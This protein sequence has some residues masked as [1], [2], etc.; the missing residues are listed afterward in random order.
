MAQLAARV[1][2]LCEARGLLVREVALRGDEAA[3]ALGGDRGGGRRARRARRRAGTHALVARSADR[4]KE[5]RKRWFAGVSIHPL[6]EEP[7]DAE[8]AVDPRDLEITA[9]T[10]RG[11]GGQHVNRTATAVR[12]HHRPSGITSA[13]SDERSAAGQP[14]ARAVARIAERLA[15]AAARRVGRGR[16]RPADGSPPSGAR[17]AGAHLPDLAEGRA[18]SPERV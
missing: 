13:C 6:A 16:G 7:S 12:V 2:A 1:E 8:G 10:S 14:A 11:P 9:T 15:E 4:G 3:P 5:A 18:G 17:R